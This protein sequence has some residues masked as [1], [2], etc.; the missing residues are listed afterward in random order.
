MRSS[1]YQLK[2]AILL[3]LAIITAVG[4]YLLPPIPQNPLYHHFADTRTLLYIPNAFNVLSNVPFL[5]IGLI[6][7]RYTITKPTITLSYTLFFIGIFL[8][9]FGSSYYHWHP[10]NA[11][12]I[13]DR[14]PMSIAFMSLFTA[15][16][17]ERISHKLAHYLLLPLLLLGMAS[18]FYW[19]YTETIGQGDLRFYLFIQFFPMLALPYMLLLFPATYTHINNLWLALIAYG[20]AKLAEIGDKLIYHLSD[21][22]ISGHSIK[23]L[24]AALSAYFIYR[25]LR[26][27]RLL[28]STDIN[29]KH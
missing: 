4:L 10:D 20:F 5:F 24:L 11:S 3:L 8:V 23:H 19:Y 13:W 16:I 29:R 28:K 25:Y 12:L 9:S 17:G 6:G 22:I 18:V 21:Y 1:I 15:I 7:F 14:L 26:Q 2:C 27:R